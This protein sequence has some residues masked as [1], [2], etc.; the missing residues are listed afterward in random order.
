MTNQT[1]PRCGATLRYYIDGCPTLGC[2]FVY[3]A[4]DDPRPLP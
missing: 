2:G 3:G 4:H 1:C